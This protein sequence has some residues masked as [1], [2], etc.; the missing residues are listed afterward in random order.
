MLVLIVAYFA[1]RL[2]FNG[3]LLGMALAEFVGVVFMVA[4]MSLTFHAFNLRIL[5]QDT[6]RITAATALVVG[7]GVLAG[8]IPIPWTVPDR[9]EAL[10]KLG[11]IGLGCL[12]MAWPAL[13]VTSS[14]SSAERRSLLDAMV[15]GR[16]R[17]LQPNN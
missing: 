13:L 15:P 9:L 10:V 5:V 12:I 2:G 17:I 1:G 6:L 7:A 14:I 11:E 4:A 8:R 3:V 16:R